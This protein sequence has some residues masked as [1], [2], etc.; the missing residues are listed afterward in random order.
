MNHFLEVF[1]FFLSRLSVALTQVTK[2]LLLFVGKQVG[3]L[4]HCTL[5]A[6]RFGFWD[7]QH[8]ENPCPKRKQSSPKISAFPVRRSKLPVRSGK[9]LKNGMISVEFGR[10]W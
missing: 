8:A 2:L 6:C 3:Y 10:F 9:F 4:F 7:A 1:F 5:E